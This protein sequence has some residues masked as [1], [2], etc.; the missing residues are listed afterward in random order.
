MQ[1]P[2][3]PPTPG[4]HRRGRPVS[5]LLPA[6]GGLSIAAL[7]TLL[8]VTLWADRR[9][10]LAEAALMT[11]NLAHVLEEQTA[12]S[13]QTVAL[14]LGHLAEMSAQAP[15][16]PGDPWMHATLIART[17]ELR[18]V[19]A[20][21]VVDAD[22]RVLHDSEAPTPPSFR[23]A[24]REYF[25]YHREGERGL[26]VGKPL[27]NRTTGRMFLPVSRRVTT[28][29][30]A[31]GGVV[32]AAIEPQ[33]FEKV[34][35]SLDVGTDGLINL[36]HWDGE[37]IARVPA[38][39]TAIGQVI[40]STAMLRQQIAERGHAAGELVSK[41]D[42]INRVFTAR[43]VPGLP[44]IVWVGLSESE[45]L[46][47][48]YRGTAVYA[49]VGLAFIAVTGWLT[50][51]LMRELRRREHRMA[52]I[53]DSES[54][55]RQ[56][57]ASLPVGVTV[58][59]RDGRVFLRNAAAERLRGDGSPLA[60]A[61]VEAG[62][63]EPPL[64]RALRTAEPT[65]NRVIALDDPAGARR[66]LLHSAVP[67]L[68]GRGDL[69]GA[70]AVDEDVTERSE[71]VANLRE[72]EARYEAMFA[73]SIDGIILARP[74]GTILAAN[75]E[76]CRCLGYTEQEL[77]TLGRAGIVEQGS[78]QVRELIERRD[79]TGH[80]TG[81]ITLVRKDGSRLP[82]ELSASLFQDRSGD[83][84]VVIIMRDITERKAAEA[85]I[86]HLAYHD[87][88]TDLPNRTLLARTVRD[89]LATGKRHPRP[90]ALMLVDLDGFKLINDS[91]GHEVGDQLLRE[92][93][94][95]LRDSLRESDIVARLGGDEFVV[96]VAEPEGD[97]GAAAVARKIL[98]TTAQPFALAGQELH[99]TAS[100][101]VSLHPRDGDDMRTLLRNSDLAMYRAKERGRNTFEYYSEEMNVRSRRRLRL[102]SALR[103]A[104][105]D[106][107][108]SLHYQPKLDLRLGTITG[109]EALLRWH[110]EDGTAVAPTEFIPVAEE[111]GLILPIGEWVLRTACAQH[112][113]WREAGVQ[114]PRIAV[115]LSA[116]QMAD[117]HLP[118]LIDALV[119]DHGGGWL[120]LELT[121]SVAMRNIVQS[122]ALLRHFREL[123]A[124]V[125][126]DDFGTGHSSLSY[127][128]RLPVDCVKIDRAFI[129]DVPHDLDDTAITRGIVALA[130][131]LRL[132]VVAEGVETREQLDFL[133]RLGCDEIQGFLVSEPVPPDLLAGRIGTA[134]TLAA[135]VDDYNRAD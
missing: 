134:Q 30:G 10:Y 92:V 48:W 42:R 1:N 45:V 85:R 121:E 23:V 83:H 101:G 120:E 103:R 76:A 99:L 108:L 24:D 21:F 75:P 70:I 79:R 127:L 56:V 132:T 25:H 104:V 28:A 36:R 128:S 40:P 105:A 130:H 2:P 46:A 62:A 94:A 91:L 80:A 97:E 89:R 122:G 63:E 55:L 78:A 95:R 16:P 15:R 106:G 129:R 11:R 90:F 109:V 96:L 33:Y 123:G 43:R 60:P 39:P 126:I 113:R 52:S 4:T 8:A 112:G 86:Q 41:F 73:N 27:V 125:T 69:L 19:R 98:E 74:D 13:L 57:L 6:L 64:A 18:G 65:L 31:F 67:I 20:L 44:L 102:E 12:R 14:T 71:L 58:T 116:R 118:V 88:L 82:S 131:S 77:R 29:D 49:G 66:T 72:S 111:T 68:G 35:A 37:L 84:K 54:L 61:P 26:F 117:E 133:R 5:L 114:V 135:A 107:Q 47:P 32:V 9:G 3:I 17:S 100:I 34:F 59:G 7:V 124:R 93:A 22:G 87:E 38:L 81:E 51:L 115:N 110:L 50:L 53:A 119:R